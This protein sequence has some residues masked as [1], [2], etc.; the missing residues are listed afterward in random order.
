MRIFAALVLLLLTWFSG[1]EAQARVQPLETCI[2]RIGPADDIRQTL[3]NPAVFACNARQN[4]LGGGDFLTY[5]R[6]PAV[7]A[8]PDDPLVLRMTNVWQDHSRVHF[9]YADGSR[10]TLAFTS[11]DVA[12]FTVIGAIWEF[13]VP[14][15]SAA[16][17]GVAIENHGAINLRGVV[18]APRIMPLSQAVGIKTM[19]VAVY[20][21]F[22]GLALALIVYNIALWVA[23]R[24]RFQ[25]HYCMMVSALVAYTFSSSGMIMLAFSGIDNNDRVKLNGL[26]LALCALAALN[27]I[28]SFFGPGVA[29]SRVQAWARVSTVITLGA[30]VVFAIIAP[31]HARSLDRIYSVAMTAML[32]TF[33]PI[34][35]NAWRQ[36][37]RYVWL[38]ILAW[39][40]PLVTSGLRVAHGFDLVG[41]SLWL[42]NG[43]IIALAVE[44]LIS[45]IM[46]TG[47]LR[48]LSQERD[49]AVA[50]EKTAR[51]LANTD[52]LTGLLNRRAFLDLAIG[53]R[54]RHCLLLIDIDHFKGVNDQLGHDAGDE[55]LIEVA[56]AIQHCRPARS[57]AVRL[58]GE[59]FALL[60]P[61]ALREPVA[62]R[63]LQS[64]RD[65]PMPQ[66]IRVTV[67]IGQAEGSLA[68]EEDWKR[69]YRQADAALY[70]A[71]SEGRD[72]VC[73]STDFRVVA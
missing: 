15:R 23:Q 19:L 62:E 41:Y 55:V 47:R 7:S 68:S 73:A 42:D 17:S 51:R 14:Y 72:R 52:P 2:A 63:V 70:R 37:S 40:A 50:Q 54:A 38:F 13:P 58:G 65:Y 61:V 30:A 6:F 53:R 71:K 28:R 27:F 29:T 12:R 69:L 66:G 49:Y 3:E 25:L 57:L 20:S 24:H 18:I 56:A 48:S 26:L 45:S 32:L 31:I 9:L 44:S 43:N 34:L 35:W 11:A 22:A 67:S 46:V 10:E 64:V 21:G 39:A 1:A 33:L 60:M 8:V 59:E 4:V 16:L 5:L 36:R